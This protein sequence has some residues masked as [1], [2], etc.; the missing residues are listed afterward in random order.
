MMYAKL[1]KQYVGALDVGALVSE[2]VLDKLPV[3]VGRSPDAEIRVEDHWVSR[4]HCE[5]D[6]SHGTLVVRD[7]GSKH[8]TFVN[9]NLITESPL[10]P[11]DILGVGLTVFQAEGIKEEAEA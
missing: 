3:V 11:G 6:E 9:N 1:I 7:L 5:I 2:I 4:R 8:G 10:L